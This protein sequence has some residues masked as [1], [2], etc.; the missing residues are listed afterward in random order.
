MAGTLAM[1]GS[2]SRTIQ[3]WE[4]L[5]LRQLA[6]RTFVAFYPPTNL[7]DGSLHELDC[8]EPMIGKFVILQMRKY[9]VFRLN[10]VVFFDS[11]DEQGGYLQFSIQP[12]ILMDVHN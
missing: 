7:Y 4:S 10:E 2:A 3:S 12:L 1:S 6:T 5:G 8:D 9:Q 11:Y